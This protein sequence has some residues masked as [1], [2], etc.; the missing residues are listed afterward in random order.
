M[1]MLTPGTP[2]YTQIIFPAPA[3]E[4]PYVILN[5]V[6]SADGRVTV[7]GTERGLG[8]STD[9]RLMR[10]LRFHADAVLNGAATLRTSGASPTVRDADLE[11]RRRAL[12]KS[13]A[14][15]AAVISASGDLP[16]DTRFFR[17]ERFESVV[18]LTE[19]TPPESRAAV[20]ATGRRVVVLPAAGTLAAMLRWLR[21][22]ADCRLLLCEGGPTL[23]GALLDAG[24]VD[25]YFLTV[26]AR[27]VNGRDGLFPFWSGR[28]PSREKMRTLALL[29]AAADPATD[30]VYLR[31][32]VGSAAPGAAP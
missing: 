12:G 32:R 3:A 4:R 14:P 18:F 6:M 21:D 27:L 16:L 5:M 25:E 10:E 17:S 20:A 1:I 28:E 8:S 26:S 31:Y 9:Q 23:N 11:E 19:Q 22:E 7:E 29:S 30:E 13:P 2:D 24:L 15:L